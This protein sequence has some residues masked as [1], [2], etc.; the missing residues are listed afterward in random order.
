L[1]GTRDNRR[2]GSKA[3]HKLVY[4]NEVDNGG[5]FTAGE[6]QSC[7]LPMCEPRPHRSARHNDVG[8]MPSLSDES[9][10]AA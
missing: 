10:R 9:R 5:Y 6:G 3:F 2:S 7:Y 8:R 1:N 4:L